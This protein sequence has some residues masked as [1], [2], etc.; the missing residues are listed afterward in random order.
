M[1]LCFFQDQ[2][3][4][5]SSSHHG[6]RW[7]ADTIQ[8]AMDI[9]SQSRDVYKMMCAEFRLPSESTV[10]RLSEQSKVFKK[11]VKRKFRK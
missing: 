1:Q 9:Y 8:F 10:K 4:S 7:S 6:M 2:V 11:G 3:R 5:A